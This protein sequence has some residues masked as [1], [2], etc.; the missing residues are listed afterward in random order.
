MKNKKYVYAFAALAT[1][2]TLAT[3]VPVFAEDTTTPIVPQTNN[4]VGGGKMFNRGNKEMM[5]PGVAGTVSAVSGNIITVTSKQRIRRENN[6]NTTTPPT[7]ATAITYT[8]DATNAK[9]TKNNVAGTI[10]SIVIGDTIVAQGTLT[11]TNL[12][13]T[14]IRDGQMM[15]RGG[16]G[17]S[18]QGGI[19]TTP[20]ASPIVGDGKPIVAG[21]V[22]VISGSTITITNKS[23]VTYTVDATNAKIV[24]GQNTITISGIT[25]GDNVIAQGTINGNSVVATSVIDQ[26]TPVAN[27]TSGADQPHK[28]FFSSIGS[29]FGHLFGF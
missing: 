14:N 9:I 18:L 24:Q 11:G 16:Q 12:I 1:I 28:G 5:N 10:S 26:K 15:G 19:G 20:P 27:T 8:V 23:N 3:A 22:S 2:T 25:V 13:A 4:G 21:T 17:A 6:S 7:T 29:F